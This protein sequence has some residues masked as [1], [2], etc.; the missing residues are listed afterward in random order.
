MS[1]A[2]RVLQQI[3]NKRID[4]DVLIALQ[5]IGGATAYHLSHHVSYDRP[6]ISRSLQRM[7]RQGIVK[8]NGAYWEWHCPPPIY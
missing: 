1:W 6:I 2:E 5:Y 7:K 4:N 3:R 8:N